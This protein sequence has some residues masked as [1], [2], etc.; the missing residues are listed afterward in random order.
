MSNEW[1]VCLDI[2]RPT[3]C[4]LSL[5]SDGATDAKCAQE[6]TVCLLHPLPP[7]PDMT[8]HAGHEIGANGTGQRGQKKAIRERERENVAGNGAAEGI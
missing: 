1:K 3:D 6:D 4:P 2:D 7:P 8:R 5:S